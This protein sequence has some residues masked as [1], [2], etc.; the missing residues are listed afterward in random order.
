MEDWKQKPV[1]S[2]IKWLSKK[3]K[4]LIVGDFGCGEGEIGQVAKQKVH[5]FDLVALHGHITECD[6]SHVPLEDE[7]LDIAIFCLSL[8]GTNYFDYLLEANRVLKTDGILKISEVESRFVK[9]EKFQDLLF[10]FGFEFIAKH[11]NGF[12]I[13]FEFKK[14]EKKTKKPNVKPDSVLKPCLYKKR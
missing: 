5:S 10:K 3:P 12:F 2:M 14:K 7:S 1:H 6:I 11:N 13:T 4:N 9:V 8:M